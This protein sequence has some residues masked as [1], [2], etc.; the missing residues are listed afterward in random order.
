MDNPDSNALSTLDLIV[1][2]KKHEERGELRIALIL[3][4]LAIDQTM[5]IALMRQLPRTLRPEEREGRV[6]SIGNMTFGYK[7]K[8]MKKYHA[9]VSPSLWASMGETH[10]LR[11][12]LYH[13]GSGATA[14]NESVRAARENA[15]KLYAIVY[16]RDCYYDM[17]KRQ[18]GSAFHD[19]AVNF[20]IE[21]RGFLT[22]LAALVDGTD[23]EVVVS[24]SG[25]AVDEWIVLS[26]ANA[27]RLAEK[28]ALL[29]NVLEARDKCYKSGLD[30]AGSQLPALLEGCKLLRQTLADDVARVPIKKRVELAGARNISNRFDDLFFEFRNGTPTLVGASALAFQWTDRF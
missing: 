25:A 23:K 22:E 7:V 14:T 21:V 26:M 30:E 4:D 16:K 11:N 6:V 24:E 19:Q 27:N 1:A 12:L 8:D 9:E 18:A 10:R 17:A 15:A 29:V 13:N 3:F 20:L 2:A 5:L 28:R